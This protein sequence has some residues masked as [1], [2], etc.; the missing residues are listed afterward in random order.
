MKK[1][2][3][4]VSAILVFCML[5]T[6]Q[7]TAFAAHPFV[8][9]SKN[10]WYGDAVDYVY[11]NGLMSGVSAVV[12]SPPTPRSASALIF[13]SFS[14]AFSRFSISLPPPVLQSVPVAACAYQETY[15]MP[16]LS[17][18]CVFLLLSSPLSVRRFLCSNGR[19][20]PGKGHCR[21]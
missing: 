10:D 20:R 13:T 2:R 7:L 12:F 8:D 17:S 5:L 3:N 14:M 15:C 18:S 4:I 16:Q 21:T 6:M 1:I 19:F 11:N 9:V